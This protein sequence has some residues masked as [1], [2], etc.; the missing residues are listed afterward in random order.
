MIVGEGL[1]EWYYLQSIRNMISPKV[2]P[3]LREHK[4][5]I[6]YI[7]KKIKECID[8]NAELVICLID[9]DNKQNS[10]NTIEYKSFKK[11]YHGKNI[12]G[13]NTKKKARV[14]IY[15]NF[16]CLEIWFYYFFRN[17]TANITSYKEVIKI[18]E[19]FWSN[20]DKTEKYFKS[21]SS[22]GGIHPY[23]TNK[24]NGNFNTALANSTKSITNR[25]TRDSGAYSDM[26]TLFD[27]ILKETTK[28][29]LSVYDKA[30]KQ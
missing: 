6:G 21:L 8:D 4:D 13:K 29:E 11:E 16:P 30:G 28:T 9:M 19:P 18:L 14:E 1:T 25:E 23:I 22:Y 20:Y 17:S 26:K 5:G 15:E 3:N 10:T 7:K 12:S 27:K 24:L 2:K